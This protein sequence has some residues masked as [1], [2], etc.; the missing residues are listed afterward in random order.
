MNILLRLKNPTFWIGMVIGIGTIILS[1]FGLTAPDLTT[2][3]KVGETLI[4]AISNP[5]VVG[6]IIVYILGLFVDLT[7]LGFKDSAIVMAKTNVSQTA[8]EIIK[9]ES[10]VQ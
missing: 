8:E 1:Y 4:M 10:Q 6:S 7:S 3:A 5:Y 9:A 2:W